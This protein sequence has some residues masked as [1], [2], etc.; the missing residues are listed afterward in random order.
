[1]LYS[2]NQAKPAPLPSR[3]RMPDGSTRTDPATFTDEE[4]AAAGYVLAPAKPAFDATTHALEWEG[5]DWVVVELPAPPVV[6]R[7]PQ[8]LSRFEFMGLLTL[9]ERQALKA[10]RAIDPVIDDALDLLTMASHI[11]P[12]HAM[13]VQM[14]GY[15]EQI[16][17]MSSARRTAFVA[18]MDALAR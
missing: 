12:T 10:R 14:L 9:Q 17:I 1:M 6:V 18:A 7:A 2:R 13:V 8:R 16:G 4:I 3:L 5:T 11:E 15:V